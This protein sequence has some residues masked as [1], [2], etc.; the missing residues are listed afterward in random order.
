MGTR[1]TWKELTQF[2]PFRWNSAAP[3]RAARVAFGVVVP[4]VLG[5]ISGHTEY[6]AYAALGALPAGLASFQGESRSRLGAVVVACI[7]MAVS[8]FVGAFAAAHAPWLLL[9]LVAVW[10]Y[11]TGLAISLGPWISVAV[12]QWS[13]A[14]LIAVGL[15]MAPSDAALRAGLVLAGGLFQALLVI[16]LWLLRP[17]S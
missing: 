16:V 12:L 17:G 15:P 1:V 6:G 5:L 7:G 3:L 2:G 11:F 10:G 8:T 4:L 9:P 14:L 13:V